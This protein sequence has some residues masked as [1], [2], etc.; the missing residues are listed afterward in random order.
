ME[1]QRYTVADLPNFYKIKESI[2]MEVI[3]IHS[4][5]QPRPIPPITQSN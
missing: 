4:G 5:T 3:S 2:G 1:I